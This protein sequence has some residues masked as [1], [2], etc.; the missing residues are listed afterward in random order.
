MNNVKGLTDNQKI[1]KIRKRSMSKKKIK[2]ELRN[3]D[4]TCGD[5]CCTDYGV[6]LFMDGKEMEHPD[7]TEGDYIPN[8]YIGDDVSLAL[9]SILTKLGYD[10]EITETHD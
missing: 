3:W 8:Q 2:I 4:Y 9:L 5:G 10:V 1:N 6:S 7:S